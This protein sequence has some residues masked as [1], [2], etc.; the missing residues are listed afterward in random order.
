MIYVRVEVDSVCIRAGNLQRAVSATA[1]LSILGGLGIVGRIGMGNA[2]DRIGT[3][4][5]LTIGFTL[6]TAT[7][8]WLPFIKDLGMF[9]VFAGVFGFAWGGSIA[10]QSPL[11]AESFGLK[12]H[13]AIL[14]AIMSG[15]TFGSGVGPL[16]AGYMFD[17]NGNYQSAFLVFAILSLVSLV[18]TILLK[19]ASSAGSMKTV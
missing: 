1:I 19:P 2:A 16:L 9:Y 11:L 13:G 3:K 8:F 14:G 6:M 10:L 17:V 15:A 4:Q 12:A 5:S 7:L 18:L